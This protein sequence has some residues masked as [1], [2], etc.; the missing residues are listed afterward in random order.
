VPSLIQEFS[1]TR[2]AKWLREARTVYTYSWN[3]RLRCFEALDHILS[4]HG[5][6]RLTGHR[7][8]QSPVNPP[9]LLKDVA[10]GAHFGSAESV[11]QRWRAQ[12]GED[13]IKRWVGDDPRI[14]PREAFVAEAKLV[15]FWSYR[16]GALAVADRF[17]MSLAEVAEAYLRVLGLWARNAPVL[18]ACLPAGLPP[19]V[20]EDMEVFAV[21]VFRSRPASH[22]ATDDTRMRLAEL[23]SRIVSV[24]LDDAS[25]TP[26]AAFDTIRGEAL[27][28]FSEPQ[29]PIATRVTY[30]L[31][32]LGDQLLHQRG[33]QVLT[34]EQLLGLRA[35]MTSLGS[36]L[37]HLMRDTAA[38][39][40]R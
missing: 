15:S 19:C 40:G 37:T 18:A 14:R 34:Q 39:P 10:R 1:C 4:V 32:E 35:E 2:S 22:A 27:R 25:I 17:E 13:S 28:L 20:S 29:D 24:V 31:A 33:E 16:M 6:A 9:H 38:E 26:L 30:A 8:H 21:R 23:A 11:Y 3:D 5:G 36:L 12:Q 7:R